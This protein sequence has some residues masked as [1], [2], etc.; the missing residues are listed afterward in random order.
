M[1]P[2]IRKKP[3]PRPVVASSVIDSGTLHV[4]K[5]IESALRVA[6]SHGRRL[7]VNVLGREVVL[8]VDNVDVKDA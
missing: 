4:R 2:R 7:A 8:T 1:K 3:A 6:A 5:A